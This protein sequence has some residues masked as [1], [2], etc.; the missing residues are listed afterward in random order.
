[1]TELLYLKDSY[2]KEFSCT[3]SEI[4]EEENAIILNRTAFYP[5]GGGQHV[6]LASW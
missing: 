5:G 3:V 2:I 1:M 6:I 4:V